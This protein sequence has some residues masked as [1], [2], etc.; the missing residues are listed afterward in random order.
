MLRQAAD[1]PK[2]VSYYQILR[3]E[4]RGEMPAWEAEV[5]KRLIDHHAVEA[6]CVL[7][8]Y[9]RSDS[10]ALPAPCEES[11]RR[12]LARELKPARQ[13][14]WQTLAERSADRE[15]LL[16]E[17]DLQQGLWFG[18]KQLDQFGAPEDSGL[19]AGFLDHP[20]SGFNF[21][22]DGSGTRFFTARE[23]AR[24]ALRARHIPLAAEVVTEINFPPPEKS[25]ATTNA[26][27]ATGWHATA[28][29]YGLLTTA[30][31]IVGFR[32]RRSGAT[33]PS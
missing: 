30:S 23:A 16:P 9:P 21:S 4:L 24:A 29:L 6:L 28:G 8:V 7:S 2:L 31:L 3:R 10:K 27:K 33:Q 17:R 25:E 5:I 15:L 22:T 26:G 20:A 14:W 1:N 18:L 19:F 12:A 32:L 13:A 11:L